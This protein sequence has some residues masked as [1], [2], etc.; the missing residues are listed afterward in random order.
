M[1]CHFINSIR[2]YILNLF[3][4][5]SKKHLP[6][7]TR[8]ISMEQLESRELLN[9]YTWL[10]GHGTNWN[11]DLNWQ[12]GS[13]PTNG[14]DLVFD[15]YATTTTNNIINASFHSL[16]FDLNGFS[17]SAD[18]LPITVTERIELNPSVTSTTISANIILS[19][20]HTQIIVPKTAQ[21]TSELIMNGVI[22][23][24][25]ENNKCGITKT[26]GGILTLKKVNT[27]N[28]DTVIGDTSAGGGTVTF[29]QNGCLPNTTAL[30][31]YGNDST[32]NP[33]LDLSFHTQ[34]VHALHLKGGWISSGTL[35]SQE[36]YDLESGKI[37]SNTTLSNANGYVVG[38][39]K[40]TTGTVKF[41][42]SGTNYTG[43]TNE[44]RRPRTG[45]F[46]AGTE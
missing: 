16:K 28:G 46:L 13:A 18:S 7:K 44:L 9:I 10:G 43:Q 6:Y 35:Q 40:T 24:G 31:I 4:A 26:G 23:G 11:T 3:T 38:L 36:D 1:F 15:N 5:R 42:M 17:I 34:E 8:Y 2:M 45:G 22:S 27:Y 39:N 33:N 41:E 20:S 37:Y 14:S 29:E 21:V 12:G 30:T 32:S 19:A 25:S